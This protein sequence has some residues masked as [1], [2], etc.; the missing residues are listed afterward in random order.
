MHAGSVLGPLGFIAYTEDIVDVIERQCS[1]THIRRRH[2]QLLA[3]AKL[4]DSSRLRQQL[5][6]C[7]ADVTQWCSSRRLQL[8]AEKID[9]IWIGSRAA[10]NKLW[11]QDQSLTVGTGT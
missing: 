6:D 4:E 9:V 3:S 5:S 2:T 7:V 8:N 1:T 11:S 10:T